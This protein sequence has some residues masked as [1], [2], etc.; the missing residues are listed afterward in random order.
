MKLQHHVALKLRLLAGLGMLSIAILACGMDSGGISVTRT[1]VTV[2]FSSM[3]TFVALT[4]TIDPSNDCQPPTPPNPGATSVTV[5][6]NPT[7]VAGFQHWR[8]NA[9]GGACTQ[10]QAFLYRGYFQFD[11]T[12]L[13]SL[14]SA[15]PAPTPT[16]TGLYSR[17]TLEFD[18]LST[19]EFDFLNPTETSSDLNG[20]V[21]PNCAQD[22]QFVRGAWA[23]GSPDPQSFNGFTSSFP[24]TVP[25]MNP[26]RQPVN[27][28]LPGTL[29]MSGSVTLNNGAL[30]IDSR[31]HVTMDVTDAV[32]AWLPTGGTT[33]G[34]N[35]TNLGLAFTSVPEPQTISQSNPTALPINSKCLTNFGNFKLT[36]T[37]VS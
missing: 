3:R 20:T 23:S 4:G 15:T 35:A 2:P 30:Q 37:L 24:T 18:V 5:F 22:I 33:G 14:L 17:A 9:D 28:S 10:S 13:L 19:I 34:N 25:I 6:G 31:G 26:Q 8:N 12:H 16:P 32:R 1:N 36:V 21:I 27:M 11:L 29:P 7:V